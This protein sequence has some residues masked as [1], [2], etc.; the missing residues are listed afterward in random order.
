MGIAYHTAT[1]L[2]IIFEGI[3][4]GAYMVLFIQYIDL[5]RRN[6]R[7]VD[8]PLALAQ[9]L[10][11]GLCTLCFC[12]DAPVAYLR[13]VGD[14][15]TSDQLDVGS[16]V[17]FDVIDF[18]AQMI[19]LYRCWII[20]GRRLIVVAIPGFLALV[21]LA[22]GFALAGLENS[23][24]WDTDPDKTGFFYQTI[25]IMTYTISLAVNALATSL[26]VTKILL[27]SREVRSVLGSDSHRPFRIVTAMLIESGLLTFAFQLVFVVLFSI[28]HPAQD[29]I[30]FPIAQIYGITPILLNIRVLL[31]STYDEAAE[32]RLSLSFA[33]RGGAPI[34]A[35]VLSINTIRSWGI[36]IDLDNISN[37]ERDASGVVKFKPRNDIYPPINLNH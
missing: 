21:S 6:N 28:Q 25:G 2:G 17:I 27:T 19:L 5:W 15:D 24:L 36:S 3:L 4:Y 20:W 35:P 37:S 32:R 8:R 16:L 34:R 26:I 30:S 29:L 7:V 31:G 12:F 9:I 22:G 13:V 23:P 33:R 1:A 18:L 10:L 14:G 11:F